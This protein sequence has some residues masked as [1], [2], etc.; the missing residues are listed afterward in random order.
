MYVAYTHAC[1]TN[2]DP[3]VTIEMEKA[4]LRYVAGRQI[5]IIVDG[6]VETLPLSSH[7]HRYMLAGFQKWVREGTD[8]TLGSTLEMARAHVVAVNAASEAAP[9]ADVPAA[10][11][12]VG[13]GPDH[14]PL[15]AIRNVV[16]AMQLATNRKCL[17]HELD[18]NAWTV[19]AGTKHINGY[20]HFGGPHKNGKSN[21]APATRPSVTVNVQPAVSVMPAAEPIV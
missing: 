17:L 11:V 8:S 7:P 13:T 9:V 2:I 4:R 20:S 19:R 5:E 3:I 15:R 21:A 1:T 18:T 16:P 10:F 12:D 14:A 6:Q